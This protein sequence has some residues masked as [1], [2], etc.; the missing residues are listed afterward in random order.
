MAIR[1]GWGVHKVLCVCDVAWLSKQCLQSPNN[2][3]LV[4][5]AKVFVA[6][7]LSRNEIVIS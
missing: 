5:E 4:Q 3:S 1:A 7:K 6:P 2:L